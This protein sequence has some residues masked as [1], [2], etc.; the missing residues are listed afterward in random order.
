MPQYNYE[1][2]QMEETDEERKAKEEAAKKA[3]T[4]VVG[5]TKIKQYEDGSQTH[6]T[7]QEV[8]APSFGDRLGQAFTR[9]GENFVNNV[10]SA[11]DRF[12]NNLN[13]GIDNVRNAPDRFMQNVSG[14]PGQM[15]Q[16][17]A[18]PVA[19]GGFQGQTDEFGGVDQAIARQAQQPAPVAPVAP[20]S[21]FDRMIQAESGG[22]QLNPQGQVLTSN[23][24]AL[25][26]AQVMPTTAMDPGYG[27]KNIFDLAQERGIPFQN[28]DRATAEQL[29]GNRALNQEFGAN[30]YA[31][32]NKKFDGGPGAVAAYNAGPGRVS[33]NMA[34]N[35]G[36]LNV[37]QLPQETQ[38]YL[39][40]VGMPAGPRPVS[41][42]QSA[43]QAMP[44]NQG[45]NPPTPGLQIPGLT[46]VAQ[47]PPPVDTTAQAINRYQ[48]IQDKPDELFKFAFSNDAP[49]YLK[50]RAKD[51]IIEKYDQEKKLA[52]ATK[53]AENL[54]PKQTADAIQGRSKS[55]VGDWLQ[56]L[57]LKHVGL[58]DLANEKG[59]ELG[60]GHSWQNATITDEKGVERGVE[61]L[62]TASGK[63]L[64]GNYTGTS[65]PISS[66]QLQEATSGILGKGVHVT[67]V[68]NRI[69]PL[70]GEVVHVQTLSNG[71]EK[72]KLG[73]KSYAGDKAVLIPEAQHTKQEDTRVNAGY[74]KLKALTANPTEQ[75]KFQALRDAGVPG[76]RIERELGLA[77]GS[78]SKATPT[79][80]GTPTSAAAPAQAAPAA[81]QAAPAQSAA[82]R[83]VQAQGEY[84]KDYK[85]RLDAWENKTK[86]QQKD[87]E[88]F[89]N[90]AVNT[91]S[92]LE[93]IREAVDVVKSGNYFM[94]PLLG[95]D[96]KRILPGAQE[97]FA[98]KFGDQTSTDNT[99]MLR[100]LLTREGLQ[101]I[102]NSMG[103]SISN[104]DVQ[105]WLKS[106][107][108]TEQSSPQAL[109]KY[110]SKLHNTLYELSEQK[111]KT[112]VEQ[113][114]LEPSFS[115]GTRLG[116]GDIAEQSPQDRARAELEKRKKKP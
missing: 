64:K 30:Y 39:Q 51:Q 6:T 72:F 116:G 25:G 110:F 27:V 89:A 76:A 58:T 112:A 100:S 101:G 87:A 9:A 35:Q 50:Q 3:G 37:A 71:Q 48:V 105:A 106:N 13:R 109:E 14:T 32:M 99:R 20:G 46:P 115:L 19:P 47:M 111:R 7:T 40:K 57:F 70:T 102:K 23:K 11:P 93:Q 65:T 43:Q 98:S 54:T 68:E 53:E 86:L 69:N 83:P 67:K 85:V 33:Q 113:G 52:Q 28:R 16:S 91:R 4:T 59:E 60:I 75:Q 5:E 29:L 42:E 73:G 24:G 62:T 80:A 92:Q 55:S 17:V 104:F 84:D 94:G 107:P 26:I 77:A 49:D 31:A 12:V 78:L 96:G 36:Q 95:T 56:Y 8:A 1:T 63:V 79:S 66:A 44:A 82:Q 88:A 81:T 45:I 18:A 15:Q 90:T 114:M 74:N 21:T 61:V 22:R 103:P 41:P 97:F 10:T 34:Q 38:G 2:G 108:A